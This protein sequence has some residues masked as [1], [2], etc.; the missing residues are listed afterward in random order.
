MALQTPAVAC[1]ANR[2]AMVMRHGSQGRPGL[3]VGVGLKSWGNR[4]CKT[5]AME[6]PEGSVAIAT[7][8][9]S[10]LAGPF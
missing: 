7:S 5:A 9:F 10:S 2:S 6:S 1:C 8:A 4:D 3:A